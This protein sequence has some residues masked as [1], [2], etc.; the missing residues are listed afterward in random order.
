VYYQ[1]VR[2]P[3]SG[4]RNNPA[5]PQGLVY[6]GEYNDQVGGLGKGGKHQLQAACGCL[7]SHAAY[8]YHQPPRNDAKQ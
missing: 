5:L 2:L 7:L 4:W 8:L 1:R 6:E 3:M